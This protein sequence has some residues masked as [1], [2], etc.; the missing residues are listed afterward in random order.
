MY[1]IN[2]NIKTLFGGN[3]EDTLYLESL[4]FN[5]NVPVYRDFTHLH[6]KLFFRILDNTDLNYY[7]FA[8]TSVGYVRNK[9]NTPWVDDYDIIVFEEDVP[10]F[11]NTVLPILKNYGYGHAMA[12]GRPN[13][14]GSHIM[15]PFGKKTFQCD[16]FYT[17]IVN[18]CIRSRDNH[19]GHY[20]TRSIF[21][22]MVRPAQM[23]TIDG[24]LTLPFFNQLEKDVM[25][26]Y[27]DVRNE[28]VI[29][30]N[31]KK[32]LKIKQPFQ[33]VYNSFNH[34]KNTII[35]NTRNKYKNHQYVE[36]ITLDQE[37][38]KLF[39]GIHDKHKKHFSFLQYIHDN[40]VKNVYI[41]DENFLVFCVDLKYYFKDIP[42]H[43]YLLNKTIHKN[44]I[45][46]LNYVD[47]ILV[48]NMSAIEYI[49]QFDAM[50]LNEPSINLIKVITFGTFDLFHIGHSNILKRA[51]AFGEL[52]VGISTDV[53]NTKKNKSSIND[54]EKR[55]VDVSATGYV[56]SVFE[57]E[58]LELKQ[59]YVLEQTAN[60]LVMGDDWKDAFNFCDCACLY[61]PR[62]PNISTTMLKQL[63]G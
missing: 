1:I 3:I 48:T 31:H 16:I 45:I 4:G 17:K 29:H 8:G 61:L 5:K 41:T 39:S 50:F 56:S 53:L 46:L 28:C 51:S 15:S 54:L 19:W 60:L 11:E 33:L 14:P 6:A 36:N 35:K 18:K 42:I 22:D 26:E 20:N 62:T 7:V 63:L 40:R 10:Y 32:S 55:K 44:N 21:V 2:Q 52:S 49:H 24:D 9:Q 57:E 34:I 25:V 37:K 38:W 58:S 30:V 43:F 12:Y 59:E 23:C 47:Q 27:G 13:G